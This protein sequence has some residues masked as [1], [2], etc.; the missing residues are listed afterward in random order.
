MVYVHHVKFLCPPIRWLASTRLATLRAMGTI[1]GENITLTCPACGAT[2]TC[3]IL[4]KGS[5]WGGSHWQ[6]PTF[7]RFDITLSGSATTYYNVSGVC[8]AC[9]ADAAVTQKYS[10]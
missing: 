9:N 8:V 7:E 1:D 4:D 5:G 3:R 10:L 2:E 6:T